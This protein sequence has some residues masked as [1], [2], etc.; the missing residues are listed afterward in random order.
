M[1][2]SSVYQRPSLLRQ[3]HSAS[4]RVDGSQLGSQGY[5]LD[6]EEKFNPDSDCSAREKLRAYSPAA[7]HVE[8]TI[9]VFAA[10]AP[11]RLGTDEFAGEHDALLEAA[12]GVDVEHQR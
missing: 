8:A 4:C 10:R 9:V 2:L 6:A 1:S 11:A 3:S 12:D 5:V 7:P